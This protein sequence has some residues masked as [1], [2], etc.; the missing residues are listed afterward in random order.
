MKVFLPN[1]TKLLLLANKSDSKMPKI[2]HK[3]SFR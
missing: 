2:N 1:E 3:V